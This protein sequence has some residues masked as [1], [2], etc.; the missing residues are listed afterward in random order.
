MCS[1]AQRMHYDTCGWL[2]GWLGALMKFVF[3]VALTC[4][5]SR[6]TL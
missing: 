2:V 4:T 1:P 6:R 5:R 3:Y